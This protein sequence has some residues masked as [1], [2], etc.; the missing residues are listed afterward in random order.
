MTRG[1]NTAKLCAAALDVSLAKGDAVVPEGTGKRLRALRAGGMAQPTAREP[2]GT[3]VYGM[4]D[5]Q[6]DDPALNGAILRRYPDVTGLGGV[7]DV[8][9]AA[10]QELVRDALREGSFSPDFTGNDLF[11]LLRMAG[12]VK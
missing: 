1:T 10:G 9:A 6:R 8:S 11:C 4:I 7:Y 3:F 12:T 5:P 2:L